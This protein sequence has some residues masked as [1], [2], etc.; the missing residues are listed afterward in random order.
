MLLPQKPLELQHSPNTEPE[1]VYPSGVPPLPLVPQ[2]PLGEMGCAELELD[3][4]ICVEL[5][6][7]GT[8]TVGRKGCEEGVDDTP[9]IVDGMDRPIAKEVW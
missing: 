5:E 3:V 8:G 2:W 9:V 6:P 4:G 7:E 1:Q